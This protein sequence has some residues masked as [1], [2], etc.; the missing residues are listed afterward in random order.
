MD[1]VIDTVCDILSS[2]L[3][4]KKLKNKNKCNLMP[5]LCD[6]ISIYIVP[7]HIYIVVPHIVLFDQILIMMCKLISRI[8]SEIISKESYRLIIPSAMGHE[9]NQTTQKIKAL[10]LENN[11]LSAIRLEF[12]YDTF[13]INTIR[14]ISDIEIGICATLIQY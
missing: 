12:S 1:T 8:T 11:Q 3:N 4:E 9:L 5:E 7:T 2:L 10:T 14:E 13:Y 6:D